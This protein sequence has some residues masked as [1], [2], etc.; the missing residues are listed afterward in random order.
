MTEQDTRAATMRSA[1]SHN[2]WPGIPQPKAMGLLSIVFQLEQ[3]QWWPAEVLQGRQFEQLESLLSFA[4]ASV[5]YYRDRFSAIGWKAGDPLTPEVWAQLP[6]LRPA[7]ILNHAHD[8]RAPSMPAHGETY[9]KHTSGSSGRPIAVT[10]TEVT[11]LFW[12]ALTLRD[13]LWHQRD[14]SAGIVSIRSG[15]KAKDPLGVY[16]KP[17]WGYPMGT[18]YHTGPMTFFYHRMPLLRQAEILCARN[19]RYLLA[20]PSNVI[21]LADHFTAQGLSLPALSEVRTYGEPVNEDVRAACRDTW[22]VPVTDVY[23]CEEIGYF[24]LQCPQ[25]QHYHVQSEVVLVEI[26][27]EDDRP[28]VPGQVG[29]AVVTSLHNFA[30]PIIRYDIGDYAEVGARCDCGRGLPVIARALGRRR[31]LA[32]LPDGRCFLPEVRRASWKPIG[33]VERLQLVQTQVGHIEIRVARAAPLSD[34]ERQTLAAAIGSDLGH[35]FEFSIT[36]LD[37]VP[38]HE[39]GK[40]EPFVS[41]VAWP[42]DGLHRVIA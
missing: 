42:D 20:Y 40:F 26:L 5:P 14:L 3:S 37:E 16:D 23:S 11:G 35:L 6:L 39:N 21:E 28:C 25:H 32:V 1:I 31:N 36:E 33:G 4:C 18:V 10:G 17:S 15:R 9:V 12:G 30:M 22:G 27:D 13:Q 2:Q 38:R 19:P 41:E 7:D 8:L 24:A 29:R 34:A